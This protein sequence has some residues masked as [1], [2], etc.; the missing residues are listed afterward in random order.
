MTS[1]RTRYRQM[2]IDLI[3]ETITDLTLLLIKGLEDIEKIP[4]EDFK[5]L[6]KMTE[7]MLV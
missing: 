7:K 3:R 6:K 4:L 1:T 2:R 5:K